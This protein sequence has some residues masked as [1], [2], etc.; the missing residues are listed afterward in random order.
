MVDSTRIGCSILQDSKALVSDL[1]GQ[2]DQLDL[3]LVVVFCSVSY[4]LPEIARELERAFPK[5]VVVGCTTA[6]EIGPKGY[7]RHSVSAISFSVTDFSVS[8]EL[9]K[10]LHDFPLGRWRTNTS[11]LHSRHNS[12][13]HLNSDSK[14]FGLL[15]VDGMSI[16]EEPL[17]RVVASAIPQ[18][19][20]I[21][22][23]AGDDLNFEQT[24]IFYQG[25][26][27]SDAALL[28][29]ITTALPFKLFKTQHFVA[30]DQR[31]VVTAAIPE[32]RIVT[33]INGLPAGPEYAR[34]LGLEG[35]EQ[36]SPMVFAAHPVV[37]K[38][39][40]AEY[41]RSIQKV[42]SDGSLTFFCAIDV[43]VV[44]RTAQGVDIVTN[45]K[46]MLEHVHHQVGPPQALITCDCILRRL[47]LEQHGL[48][49]PVSELLTN[50][51]GVGFSTYGE[52]INGVHVNQTC[53]GIAIGSHGD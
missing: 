17:V 9:Y 47:E 23:S 21:G 33:E 10:D 14:T 50:N 4:D 52:Q 15:L 45:L 43:G 30:S 11:S 44:L 13:Y 8:V 34:Q 12:L 29:L 35:M 31:M 28:I 38:M 37:V 49:S 19:P 7:S 16:R 27:W 40:D 41:V 53:T 22:G 3:A 24:Y 2:I 32:H 6:G 39:G 18:I 51:N 48:L 1:K 42:N 46:Q 25:K 5:V 20:L 26:L 36:L